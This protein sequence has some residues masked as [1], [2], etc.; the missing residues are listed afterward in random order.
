MIKRQS[1]SSLLAAFIACI[2]VIGCG[3]SA[4]VGDTKATSVQSITLTISAAA[5]L[6]D[7]LEAIAPQFQA[8]HQGIAVNFNFGSSGALQQQIVQGAPSDVFFS[9][10][11]SQMDVLE[12][13]GL[14]IPDSRQDIV[15][16]RLVLIAP[17]NSAWVI[18]DIAQLKGVN[19][20]RFAVG[21]F[22]SVPAG[23]YAKEVF[24]NLNLLE[25]L[26]SSF[27]FGNSVRGVLAAV[28]SGDA[29]LGM[30]YA[31]DAALSKRVKV[32]AIAPEGSHQ[33]ITYPIAVLKSSQI[34]DVARTFIEFLTTESAQ[35]TFVEFGFDP[36]S[37]LS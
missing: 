18:T 19:I 26:Q 9:A 10:A 25:T 30:V 21:E 3:S 16:N 37:P 35:K 2:V 22:R 34:P 5:S 24:T 1:V 6:Q 36:I 33:P 14:I 17:I 20:T 11:K 23:Q 29:E 31:T 27:V 12:Q 15:A 7:V 32:L 13:G 8:S 4:W 28:A